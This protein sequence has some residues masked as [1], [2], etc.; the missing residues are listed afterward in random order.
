MVANTCDLS[1]LEAETGGLWVQG[2]CELHSGTLSQKDIK[3]EIQQK[4]HYW[5]L[6]KNS[7]SVEVKRLSWGR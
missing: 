7:S 1:T 3:K 4:G 5:Q 6:A 2:Q